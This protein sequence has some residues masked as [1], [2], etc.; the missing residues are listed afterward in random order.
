LPACRQADIDA[1]YAENNEH[2]RMV[3]RVFLQWCMASGLTGRFRL[4][5][6]AIRH[7]APLP[8]HERVNQLDRVLTRH[9]LPLADRDQRG[10]PALGLLT[11]KWATAACEQYSSG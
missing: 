1:W 11:V 9:D 7:A 4:P 8:D 3:I 10:R 6:T 2:A 5:A